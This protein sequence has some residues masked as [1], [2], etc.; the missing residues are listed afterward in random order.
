[1]KLQYY[2]ENKQIDSNIRIIQEV[3]E[4]NSP[5][6]YVYFKLL[7]ISQNGV[8]NE[9]LIDKEVCIVILSGKACVSDGIQSYHNLGTRD[10]V[11]DRIPTD[12]IYIS[13]NHQF[14]VKATSN[15]VIALCY[16]PAEHERSTVVIKAEDNSIEKR[17]LYSNKRTVHNILTDQ[18]DIAENLLVVEVYTEGGNFSSYPPHRHDQ[19]NLPDESFLEEI[20]FHKINP[21][22]G[23]IFQRI[24]TDNYSINQA[25]AVENNDVVIVPEGY[26]PVGVPDG[27]TSYY[28]NVMAGPHRIW[29]FYNDP[30]HE[31]ILKRK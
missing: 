28:L 31:W 22:Q 14:S 6:K 25:L 13:K 8:Y 16:S 29:K 2:P 20:Y 21:E 9:Q 12:S 4:K 30:K 10:S 5:L 11:F 7:E 15:S 17:G 26:H 1:M 27:Y 3:T 18:D 19:N 24:Y 23:F